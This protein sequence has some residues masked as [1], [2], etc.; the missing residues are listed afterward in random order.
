MSPRPSGSGRREGIDKEGRRFKCTTCNKSFKQSEHCARHELMHTQQRPFPCEQCGKR[1]GRKECR[2]VYLGTGSDATENSPSNASGGSEV[3]DSSNIENRLPDTTF[4]RE[5]PPRRSHDRESDSRLADIQDTNAAVVIPPSSLSNPHDQTPVQTHASELHAE[6]SDLMHQ[7]PPF[8]DRARTFLTSHSLQPPMGSDPL[9]LR[10]SLGSTADPT[11]Y[12]S[13]E[14]TGLAAL[15]NNDHAGGH[16]TLQSACLLD[17][18][19]AD[20]MGSSAT[21]QTLG[22]WERVP[23]DDLLASDLMSMNFQM[24]I[25]PYPLDEW[26]NNPDNLTQNL[27]TLYQQKR[28]RLRITSPT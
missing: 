21:E 24:D 14:C 8:H 18:T 10:L 15:T 27:P 19:P 12:E 22:P 2:A 5:S 1:Y 13:G 7:A 6:L 28:A 3:G 11:R 26:S 17:P 16:H 25:D 23:G 20:H 9:L 4:P